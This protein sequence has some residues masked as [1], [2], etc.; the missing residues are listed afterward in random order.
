MDTLLAMK[1]R[2]NSKTLSSV[3]CHPAIVTVGG[4]AFALTV[5][6]AALVAWIARWMSILYFILVLLD[7][8]LT[9]YHLW[10][11]QPTQPQAKRY[12]LI[13]G[14]S[15]GIGRAIAY[16]LANQ[17]YSLVIASRTLEN[18]EKVRA[19]I[20]KNHPS[21][22]VLVCA[23]DLS[24]SEGIGALLAYVAQHELVIDILVN[25]AGASFTSNFIDLPTKKVEE[26]VTLDVVA[27]TQLTH[28]IAPQMV[29]RGV[30]RILNLASVS[31]SVSIP[32]AALY[33]SSKAF[34]LNFSQA[35][36][37]ELRSTGVTVTCFCPGGV[38]TNFGA[39]AKCDNSIFMTLM[40]VT[41][42]NECAKL[43]LE[44]MFNADGY[45]YDTVGNYVNALN[46]RSIVPARIGLWFGAL[47]M[48]ETDKVWKMLKR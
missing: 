31:S 45:A 4:I 12:A 34:M 35:V 46:M 42:V 32:T 44:A 33:G 2:S 43:A 9:K 38:L 20:E 6:P 41:E 16:E 47:V 26:L 40:P 13:T 15:L 19:D 14:A 25:N 24:T 39:N 7:V 21:V 36:N 11:F 17:Q 3:L 18:L 8:L 28:G 27:M 29:K 10:N 30:G 1:Q 48:N 5:A 23:C 37:Y 22:Q